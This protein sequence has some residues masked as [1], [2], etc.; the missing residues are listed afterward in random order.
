MAEINEVVRYWVNEL[1]AARKRDKDYLK[2]GR[3]ILEIYEGKKQDSTPFNIL[4]SNTETLL[5]SLFGAVPRPVVSR[6]FRDDDPL[7]KAASDAAQRALS[8]SLDPNLEIKQPFQEAVE[9]AVVDSLLPGRGNVRIK[10]DATIVSD[11]LAGEYVCYEAVD[12]NRVLFGYARKWKDMPWIAFEHDMDRQEVAALAGE[13]VA[14]EVV[15]TPG[16]EM[17][18]GE[19]EGKDYETRE[20]GKTERKTAKVYEVWHK[21]SR[22]VFFVS[23]HYSKGLMKEEDDPLEL[24]GFFPIPRPLQLLKKS[25]SLEPV[26]IYTLYENQAKELNRITVRINRLIEALKIRGGYNNQVKEIE[27]ILKKEDNTLVAIQNAQAI[28][29]AKGLEAAIWLVPIEK[30]ITVVQQLYL[31]REQCKQVIYEITGIAD[32]LRGVSKA[33]ETLGAQEIKAKWGGLR[34]K[35]AQ[36]EVARFCRDLLRMAAEVMA[37]KFQE[38]TWVAMTQLPYATTPELEQANEVAMAARLAGAPQPPPE[39]IETAT[40]V[41]WPAV[42]RLLKNDLFRSY[43]IDVETNSTLDPAATED[44]QDMVEMLGATAQFLQGVTPLVVS[45]TL[46]FQAAQ[47]VLLAIA[48]R[49]RFGNEIEA[50]LQSMQPPRPPEEDKSKQQKAEL[51]LAVKEKSMELSEQ[52]RKAADGLREREFKLREQELELA[53]ERKMLDLEKEQFKQSAINENEKLAHKEREVQQTGRGIAGELKNQATGLKSQA[54]EL[55]SLKTQIAQMLKAAEK[56]ANVPQEVKQL[57]SDLQDQLSEL[58]ARL[59]RSRPR[60]LQIVRGSDGRGKE[61]VPVYGD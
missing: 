27:D 23:S 18:S 30:L 2:R 43:R 56:P 55:Q 6:R 13:A 53:Y 19:E 57:V 20:E 58:E 24:S 5:P 28:D 39:V 4:Y 29:N 25:H 21:A 9:D 31:A 15:Y 16:A 36:Q 32:I 33:S 17:Q 38:N 40:K 37:T 7:G 11:A 46:P 35:R 47:Q 41:P 26:A 44:K 22:K 34:I 10:Y 48:R 1:A 51:D 52:E 3:N 50:Q 59:A 54:Q 14:A 61:L 45:G 42:L 60:S 49:F 12:W 8:Y